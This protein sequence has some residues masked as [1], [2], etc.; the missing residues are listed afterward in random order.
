[1]GGGEAARG[2]EREAGD[3]REAGREAGSEK[4]REREAGMQNGR[5][6]KGRQA[7][8]EEGGGRGGAVRGSFKGS[9]P[10]SLRECRRAAPSRSSTPSLLLALLLRPR[11]HTPA[12]S[13]TERGLDQCRKSGWELGQVEGGGSGAGAGGKRCGRGRET[14]RKRESGKRRYRDG[15]GAARQRDKNRN[16][17]SAAA[18][19][20]AGRTA[21]GCAGSGR[22][23]PAREIG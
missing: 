20:A 10:L 13:G 19:A 3:V 12:S 21:H 1:M 23:S 14:R 15:G 16:P 8:R 9:P 6:V 5:G 2:R 4:E 17:P 22:L 11:V 18:A 7:E